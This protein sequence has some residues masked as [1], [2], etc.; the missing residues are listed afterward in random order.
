MSIVDDEPRIWGALPACERV[1]DYTDDM[2]ID[3]ATCSFSAYR[4]EMGVA[5]K[6]TV[7]QAPDWF[8]PGYE[9]AKDL[10]PFGIFGKGDDL[11]ADWRQR[12]WDRL[13]ERRARIWDRLT[14][15]SEK[16]GGRTLVLLC[17]ENVHTKGRESCHRSIVSDWLKVRY[18]LEVPELS[19]PPKT[20]GAKP[21]AAMVD[22]QPSLF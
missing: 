4:R 5:V 2:A 1:G 16:H 11:P 20:T 19:S 3:V 9:E 17:F 7:G 8:K 18:G 14:Q 10:A 22:T 21:T 13:E 12:Y 15:L 6:T